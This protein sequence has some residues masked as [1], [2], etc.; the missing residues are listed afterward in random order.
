MAGL[1]RCDRGAGG[2]GIVDLG[3]HEDVVVVT[4]RTTHRIGGARGVDADLALLDDAS[5]VGMEHLDRVLDGEDRHRPMGVDPVQ[6]RRHRGGLARTGGT[7]DE[8]EPRRFGGELLHDPGQP[9]IGEGHRPWEDTT[10]HHR[11]RAALTEGGDPEAP[12]VLATEGEIGSAGGL[13]IACA[14]RGE[15]GFCVGLG[16]GGFECLEAFESLQVTV[17]HEP[18]VESRP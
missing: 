13:E 11:Y 17:R 18:R 10:Q 6:D 16:V 9:E 5:L 14:A 3:D 2:L 15:E 4:H 12:D 1:G 8:E 7:G